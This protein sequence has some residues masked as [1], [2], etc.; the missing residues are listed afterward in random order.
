MPSSPIKKIRITF[1]ITK[2]NFLLKRKE[3]FF[4]L[5]RGWGNPETY[6]INLGAGQTLGKRQASDNGLE[7]LG[8]QQSTA[9]IAME[10]ALKGWRWGELSGMFIIIK[11]ISNLI[12]KNFLFVWLQRIKISN[13]LFCKRRIKRLNL[14]LL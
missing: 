11:T 7:G 10:K 8:E 2:L 3:K 13:S 14:Y 12:K 4:C 9:M 5:C 6:S 1:I